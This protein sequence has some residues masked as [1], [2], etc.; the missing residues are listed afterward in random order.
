MSQD[1]QTDRCHKSRFSEIELESL[2]VSDVP[3]LKGLEE[4]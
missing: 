3:T 4:N 2:H 1:W